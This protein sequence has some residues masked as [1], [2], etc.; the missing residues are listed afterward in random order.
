MA[1]PHWLRHLIS[2]YVVI[3]ATMVLVLFLWYMGRPTLNDRTH[4]FDEKSPTNWTNMTNPIITKI[5]SLTRVKRG[6]TDNQVCGHGLQTRQKGLIFCAP[7]NQAA[8]IIIPYAALTND[9]QENGQNWG[10]RYDWYATIGF[11]WEDLIG[12][13]GYDWSSW[14]KRTA[15]EHRK[16]FNLSKTVHSLILK[17]ESNQPMCLTVSLW[18]Y[19][20]GKDPHFQVSLCYGNHVEPEMPSE[21]SNKGGYILTINEITT[22]DWFLVVTGVSG[23]NNNWLLLVE[24]AANVTRKDCVVCMGPRPLLRIVPAQISQDCIIPLMNATVP[25]KRCK[26]WDPIYPVTEADKHKPMFSTLVAPNNFTCINMINKGKKLGPLN[27]TQCKV[28]LKV[29]PNFVPISRSDIWW[30]CGDDRLFD[31]LPKDKSGLCAII[32]L[33]L[34]VSVYPIPV[35]NL[36]ERTPM[37]LSNLEHRQKRDL[38]WQGQNNPTYI[39]AIGVPRGVPNQYKLADQVA[40]GFESFICWWCTIN[41]NVDRINYIHF[42]VQRLGNWTQSGLEAVHEQLKATSL[43]TFQNRIA[44]DMLLARE[45][46]VCGMFGEQC[47]TYIPNNTASDGSLTRA[48]DGL[49]TLNHKMKNH[50]GVDTSLWDSWMD[51]FGRYKTLIS[52][53]LISI[54]VFAAILTLCGCCCIPCIRSLISKL[55]TTAITPME[56][57]LELMYPLLYDDNDENDD[58]D[59]FALTDLFPDTDDYDI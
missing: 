45:G 5:G 18:A 33:I 34:H 2:G 46:G 12:E 52:P 16:K 4:F 22:D 1:H 13:T 29:K 25:T 17:Y 23:Q 54:A 31:R 53:I 56:N 32:T 11:K 15:K 55:I 10:Y 59:D 49:R 9:A 57:R 36:M 42:N 48:I 27:D 21:T 14:S 50:S 44:V 47:C 35:Q 38:S 37:F 30:W 58:N 8:L 41:K 40:G 43:M 3:S 19:T 20:G 39:D 7:Q 26:S 51:V 6:T 28:I 24:Q